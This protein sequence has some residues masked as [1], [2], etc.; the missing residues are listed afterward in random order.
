MLQRFSTFS[1]AQYCF[2]WIWYFHHRNKAYISS[3]QEYNTS[4]DQ[5]PS[6]ISPHSLITQASF[7]R[8]F[9]PV[10]TFSIFLMTSR[11]SPSTLPKTTCLLSSQSHLA[12]VIKN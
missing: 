8:L 7:G 9:G 5:G 10:A 12:H 1:Y 2:Q 6:Y 4:P 11:L 3:V